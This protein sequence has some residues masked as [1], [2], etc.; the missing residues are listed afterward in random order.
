M[1]GCRYLNLPSFCLLLYLFEPSLAYINQSKLPVA[2]VGCYVFIN[3]NF[4]LCRKS[5]RIGSS[6]ESTMKE[7]E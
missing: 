5:R 7:E 6:A 4:G 1:Y 3:F 2:N